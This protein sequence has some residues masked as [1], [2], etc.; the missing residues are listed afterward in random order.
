MKASIIIP[1]YNRAP[2]L[3]KVLEA[4]TRQTRGLIDQ[5]YVCDDGS[6]DDTAELVA[7]YRDKLPLSY[8][9]QH[10][11]G[12]RAG[13]ARNMGIRRAATD[14]LIF[15]DDD[16]VPLPGWLEQH[17]AFHAETPR[18]V[19][20]GRISRIPLDKQVPSDASPDALPS[21]ETLPDD[22]R[23][24]LN[25]DGAAEHP[26][27]WLLL[28]SCHF[29]VNRAELQFQFDEQFQGWGLEDNDLGLQLQNQGAQFRYLDQAIVV[30]HDE[31]R[32]RSPFLQ[33]RIG[34]EPDYSSYLRNTALL[35]DKYRDD[36]ELAPWITRL[37]SAAASRPNDGSWIGQ[38]V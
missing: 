22:E 32:P 38:L 23:L 4:L 14:I 8:L 13:A 19:G 5:I 31:A 26:A 11:L 12:F 1:T 34:L 17:L 21:P 9:F 18:A 25:I 16:C 27:P 37:L 30:H 24:D 33:E 35:L 6:H 15:I 20:L 29:S 28:W 7:G 36:A 2:V 3:Q 10:D